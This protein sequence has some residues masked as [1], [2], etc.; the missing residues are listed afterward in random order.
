MNNN[1]TY[2]SFNESSSINNNNSKGNLNESYYE[3]SNNYSEYRSKGGSDM[4]YRQSNGQTQGHGHGSS[5]VSD[6]Y[7]SIANNTTTQTKHYKQH[8]SSKERNY[9]SNSNA[10]TSNHNSSYNKT[11]TSTATGTENKGSRT[12][13]NYRN[14]EDFRDNNNRYKRREGYDNNYKKHDLS[15]SANQLYVSNLPENIREW[16]LVKLFNSFGKVLRILIKPHFSFVE[17]EKYEDAIDSIMYMDGYPILGERLMVSHSYGVKRKDSQAFIPASSIKIFPN[18]PSDTD[19][20]FKCNKFGHWANHCDV[21]VE[22]DGNNKGPRK[23]FHCKAFGH[24]IKNCNKLGNYYKGGISSIGNMNNINNTHNLSSGNNNTTSNSS[25]LISSNNNNLEKNR[26]KNSDSS[27]FTQANS[28]SKQDKAE[29]N[30]DDWPDDDIVKKDLPIASI[31]R[32]SLEKNKCNQQ[33]Q[34]QIPNSSSKEVKVEGEKSNS[35]TNLTQIKEEKDDNITKTDIKYE[36]ESETNN[37]SSMRK[38]SAK[39]S[40]SFSNIAENDKKCG[41]ENLSSTPDQGFQNKSKNYL[42]TYNSKGNYSNLPLNSDKLNYV[43]KK[44]YVWSN[45]PNNT[46]FQDNSR[47]NIKNG[48]K[49]KVNYNKTGNNGN[50]EFDYRRRFNKTNANEQESVNK[51]SQGNSGVNDSPLKKNTNKFFTMNKR[52]NENYNFQYKSANKG[53]Y[54]NSQNNNGTGYYGKKFY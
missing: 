48:F 47:F 36:S 28:A 20:C 23:C 51:S 39:S 52:K 26:N 7:N 41:G 46:G 1:H 14:N 42:N 35:S 9:T 31:I 53:N 27:K 13:S 19:M 24:T 50:S 37:S 6:S 12:F 15:T 25:N 49:R 22:E 17:F 8:G 44:P 5:Q 38:F 45:E 33:S 11:R 54:L 3:Q 30:D 34:S 21:V 32:E 2:R 10:N 4:A 40:K 18:T 29:V 43:V 16:E